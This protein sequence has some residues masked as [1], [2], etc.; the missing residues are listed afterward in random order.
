MTCYVIAGPTACGKSD[1]ALKVAKEC[2]GEIV[3]MD[4]MQIYRYMDIGTAKPT[5]EEQQ[6][7]PHHMLD[8][9]EPWESFSVA[10]YCSM[11]EA[12]AAEIIQRGKTPVFVG[13]T[14]FYLRALRHPMAMGGTSA[15]PETRALFERKAQETDGPQRLHAKLEMVDPVTAGRLHVNDVRRVIRALEVYAVT[16]KPFSDQ[17]V[18]D[19]VKPRF[20]YRV[21]S[22]N[23]ERSL[24]YERIEQRVDQMIEMGLI[25][26]VELLLEMGVSPQAQ[27]MQAIGY[28]EIIPLIQKQCSKD[29]VIAQLKLNTRHYA[30]RQLTWMRREE[31]VL[32]LNADQPDAGMKAIQYLT[33]KEKEA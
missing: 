3:C 29:E 2:N 33:R 7:I 9:V 17:P 18:L 30:K 21:I 26:E 31:D 1:L 32:W 22:L 12:C 11:A 28:K 10:A 6:E 20:S 13:G 27:A 15:S 8:I 25:K 19:Q 23:R 14:G 24:L 4:S 5:K 16:G